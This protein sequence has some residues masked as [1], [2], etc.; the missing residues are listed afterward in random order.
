MAAEMSKES[1]E[2]NKTRIKFDSIPVQTR[3]HHSSRII[4][5]L[6]QND[7]ELPL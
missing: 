4:S 7:S 5:E 1:M 6:Y 2:T 3:A